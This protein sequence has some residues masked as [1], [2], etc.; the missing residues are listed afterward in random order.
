[1]KNLKKD[2]GKNWQSESTEKMFNRHDVNLQK[3]ATIYFQ[4]GLILCLL[5][6]YGLLEM[7]FQNFKEDLPTIDLADNIPTEYTMDSYQIYKTPVEEPV[8]EK[9]KAPS[10]STDPQVVDN[11]TTG[12]ETPT[13]F[14]GED[15]PDDKPDLD[16]GQVQVVELPKDPINIMLV[17]KV[18]VF[19]GCEWATNNDARRACLNEKITHFVSNHFDADKGQSIGLEGSQKIFVNFKIT[20]NGDIEII[21]TKA[22]HIKL[23]K[24]ANRVINNL[25]KMAPAKHGNT[26][27]DVLFTLPINFHVKY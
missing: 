25:P 19:P 21:Q 23:E 5:V 13:D 12:M 4:V 18:P 17:E 26:S 3:N 22:P 27:V 20:K 11:N 2:N 24:E 10:N 14:L 7:R 16:A 1:M 9:K 15:T 6:A 8:I